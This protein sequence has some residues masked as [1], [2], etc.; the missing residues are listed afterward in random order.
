MSVRQLGGTTCSGSR[1]SSTVHPTARSASTAVAASMSTV[2][3]RADSSAGSAMVAASGG[4]P[5]TV[6]P[7]SIRPPPSWTS[8]SAT[9][10]A[11]ASCSRGSTPR[12]NRLDASEPSR[13]RRAVRAM[14][15][16]SKHAAS[17][18]TADVEAPISVDSPPITPA[19]PI[20]PRSSVISRSSGSSAPLRAVQR[21]Q[22]L[23]RPCP[24]DHDRAPQ[25]VAVVA[26]DRLSELEHH[27]VGDVDRQRDRPHPGQLDPAGQP[28]WSGCCGVEAGHGARDE[29]R[30]AA[31]SSTRT[32]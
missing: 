3:T 27:V 11:A 2:V 8:R 26:V 28:R 14:L 12:S 5:T 18:T 13:W 10:W 7:G 4:L 1:L 22:R 32:G 24:A 23:P 16:G 30:A 17:M 9:R 15:G 19:S 25:P 21:A 29:D 6:A 31:G 20:G